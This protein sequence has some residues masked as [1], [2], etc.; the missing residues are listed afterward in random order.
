M[1]L[2]DAYAVVALVVD[3]PA[4]E[5][6]EVLLRDGGCR[7]VTPNLAEAIDISQRVH[8]V[9]AAGVRAAIEPLLV[10]GVI[11]AAVP[12]VPEAWRAAE[13]RLEHYDKKTCALSMA[14]CLLLAQAIRDDEEIATADPPLAQAARADGVG[15][16][17]LPDTQGRR[18]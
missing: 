11:S 6:V 7:V 4:A 2:L 9:P 15:I 12:H 5:E 10:A 1:T 14:D 3:E 18:P 13:L 16:I 17:A 8:N